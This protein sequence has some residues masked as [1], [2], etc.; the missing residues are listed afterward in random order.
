[1][2]QDILPNQVPGTDT[3]AKA[4]VKPSLKALVF[5]RLPV[6]SCHQTAN[7]FHYD[8]EL[9]LDPTGGNTCTRAILFAKDR[10]RD[11][12]KQTYCMH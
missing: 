2:L 1:M 3:L 12:P 8:V 4:P 10:Q 9:P 5:F 6:Q 7:I 11:L